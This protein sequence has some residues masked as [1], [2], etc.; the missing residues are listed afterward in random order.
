[1]HAASIPWA[2]IPYQEG[3]FPLAL[4]T[5]FKCARPHLVPGSRSLVQ[6]LASF[7]VFSVFAN[8]V[9][10]HLR[11]SELAL[12]APPSPGVLAKVL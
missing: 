10:W 1:M 12:D 8:M 4:V 9:Q 7:I 2:E 5:M 11:V 6:R 3:P